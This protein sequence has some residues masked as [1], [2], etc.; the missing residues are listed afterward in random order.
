LK[1]KK[2]LVGALVAILVCVLY[3]VADYAVVSRNVR[4]HVEDKLAA[5]L[6]GVAQMQPSQLT[7]IAPLNFQS[8]IYNTINNSYRVI[9]PDSYFVKRQVENNTWLGLNNDPSSLVCLV[10]TVQISLDPKN[11]LIVANA[12]V[13]F[14]GP[15]GMPQSIHVSETQ[16]VKQFPVK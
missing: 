10:T 7:A 2:Y 15:F 3:Y 6:D 14:V 4:S 1:R 12:N 13:R 16:P 5:A 8:D 11:T 9:N